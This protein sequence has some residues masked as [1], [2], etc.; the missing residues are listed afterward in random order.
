MQFKVLFQRFIILYVVLYV[1]PFPLDYF[2]FN[3]GDALSSSV[4]DFWA[5]LV[6]LIS[7]YLFGFE[8]A[9]IPRTNGTGDS[10]FDYLKILTLILVAILLCFVW[11]GASLKWKM[12]NSKNI[13]NYFSIYIRYY[14]AFTMFTYGFAKVFYLQF[15]ELSLSQLT[16]QFGDASPMGLLWKF[17]GHS[18]MYSI[19]TG[20]VEVLVGILLLFR[21]TK[22]LGAL[23]CFGVMVQVFMLNMSFDVPVK[24]YSLHL[25]FMAFVVLLPDLGHLYN[26]FVRSKPTAAVAIQPYFKQPKIR[27]VQGVLKFSMIV[28]VLFTIISGDVSSQKE[29]GKRSPTN[30]LYG[31]YDV[32]LFVFNNDTIEPSRTNIE[33]W[34]RLIIDKNSALIEKMNRDRV[35]MQLEIDSLNSSLFLNSYLNEEDKND[36][37]FVLANDDLQLEGKLKDKSIRILL[38]K[39]NREDFFLEKRGF[40]WINEYPMNR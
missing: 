15:Q 14:L 6:P 17:M 5:W 8:D 23:I 26:F 10:I 4:Q 37:T 19:F 3:F 22:M 39:K 20:S 27:L 29:Y 11:Y 9:I 13:V 28:I 2:P 25:I 12:A 34:D 38:S 35:F 7:N 24:L 16:Q 32:D 1:F 30:L 40:N 31:I 33:R 36:F 18:E 21:Q